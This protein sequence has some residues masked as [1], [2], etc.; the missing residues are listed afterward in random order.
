MATNPYFTSN[1]DAFSAEQE[2]IH[3]LNIEHTKVMGI[4]LK[5]LPRTLIN[6]DQ[7]YGEDPNSAFTSAIELEFYVKSY[8]GFMSS[9]IIAKVGLEIPESLM[10]SCARRRFTETITEEFPEIVRPREGDLIYVPYPVDERKRVFEI[11]AV[12]QNENFSTLGER[13]TWEITCSVFRFNGEE[14]N[15]GDTEIDTF[16]DKYYN[17]QL[18]LNAS[19]GTFVVGDTASQTN[20]FTSTVVS[21]VN[22]IL[23]LTTAKG[24]Y[25]LALPITN[26]TVTKTIDKLYNPVSNNTNDNKHINDKKPFFVATVDTNN[27]REW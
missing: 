7:L 4:D 8:Q 13:Y 16:D 27:F 1:Y 9:A 6:Y 17:L 3:Q 26:G 14:F 5:Y 25:D 21:L 22:N 24:E 20:G 12:N 2:L 10:V 18:L 19:A 15:T 11:T 23:T